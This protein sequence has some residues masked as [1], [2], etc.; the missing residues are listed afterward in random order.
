MSEAAPIIDLALMEGTEFV[1]ELETLSNSDLGDVA[2]WCYEN[3][4]DWTTPE[5]STWTW[6]DRGRKQLFQFCYGKDATLFI[7]KWK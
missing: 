4:G 7:L 2:D 3:I 1:V 5:T 6:A